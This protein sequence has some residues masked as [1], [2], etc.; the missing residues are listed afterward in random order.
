MPQSSTPASPDEVIARART[1]LGKKT[2][3]KL[4]KGG[5]K[6]GLDTPAPAGQC[7]C[8]GYVA[9]CL[10][11]SRQMSD[12]FYQQANGGWFETTAVAKDV[13]SPYGIFKQITVPVPGC[14]AVY[15]DHG[16][17]EGH[18]GI[19]T[20]VKNGRPSLVIHCSSSA[21]KNNGD[22]IAENGI[23]ALTDNPSVVYGWFS[24]YSDAAH[25]P[26]NLLGFLKPQAAKMAR[27]RGGKKAPAVLEGGLLLRAAR[28]KSSA[29]SAPHVAKA[30][31]PAAAPNPLQVL[32]SI[33]HPPKYIAWHFPG[34][35]DYFFQS[36]AHVNADGAP[37]AYNK[38]DTGTDWLLNAGV[39]TRKLPNGKPD[40]SQPHN[41]WEWWGIS[42]DAGNNPY[43]QKA[44]HPFPGFY[45]STTALVDGTK[46]EDNPARYVDSNTIPFLVL[47]G[48]QWGG[49]RKGDLGWIINRANGQACG[50]I[51]AD[52]GPADEMGELSICAAK[53]LGLDPNPKGGGTEKKTILYLVFP[54]SGNGKPQS[55][56]DIAKRAKKLFND[57]GGDARVA[58]LPPLV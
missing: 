25:T 5:F 14:I 40:K 55:A 46:T 13:L 51:F 10:G 3:Y 52:V 31:A 47:P 56:A 30:G 37:N 57:W 18:I 49:A 38:E 19:V 2:E 20:A 28:P 17:H 23:A 1:A 48:K 27:G 8:S 43:V 6:P 26:L 44:G 21:W 4:G 22:A 12:P 42:V 39:P 16:G 11:I 36:R 45:V 34:E 58:T 50:A 41:K 35:T 15:G 32:F 24:G 33:G 53:L 29:G 54:G 9:W 7:D